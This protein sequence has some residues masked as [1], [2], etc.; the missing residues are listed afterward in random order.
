MAK[1]VDALRER[2]AELEDE[3][4]GSQADARR[5]EELMITYVLRLARDVPEVTVRQNAI[6][7]LEADLGAPIVEGSEREA[8]LGSSL[9]HA[10]SDMERKRDEL[11]TRLEQAEQV[12]R[13]IRAWVGEFVDAL[14]A[15]DATKGGDGG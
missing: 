8:L 12:M 9:V 14:D 2:A 11:R 13:G 3:L 7:D 6:R 1:K 15:Y 4:R 10:V 5:I